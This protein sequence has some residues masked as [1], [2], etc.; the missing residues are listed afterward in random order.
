M[1]AFA[2]ETDSSQGNVKFLEML[3]IYE[4]EDFK[5]DDIITRIELAKMYYKILTGNSI[6]E[7][8]EYQSPYSDIGEE[9]YGFV[10]AG[11]L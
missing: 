11:C 7:Y 9:E 3:G 6:P 8:S 1:P 4:N 5:N 2:D 10:K